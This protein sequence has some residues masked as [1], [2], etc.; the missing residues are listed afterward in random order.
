MRSMWLCRKPNRK[1]ALKTN[2]APDDGV[3]PRVEFAI[4]E[5]ESDREVAGG[6]VARA[7]A[8]CVCCRAVLPPD[9]VRSQ[10]AAQKGG[11]DAVFD[12]DGNRVGGARMTAVVTLK[13]GEQGRHYRLPTTTDYTAVRLAQKRVIYI[14]DEWERGGRQGLCPVPDEP[15]DKWS[16]A[17]N[18][19]PMY[20]MPRWGDA[21]T[22][23]QK[24]A[25]A[26]TEMA[27]LCWGTKREYNS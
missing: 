10:L 27:A 26:G 19:L 17:V 23:R 12:G 7:R 8:T 11:A 24:A 13:P 18:R 20:G 15:I 2:V 9:R 14:L 5:P 4:F 3:P 16:H 25:F 22:A 21:F 1:W 6:T